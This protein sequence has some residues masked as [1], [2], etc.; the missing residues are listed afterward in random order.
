[1]R[2]F[3]YRYSVSMTTL[4]GYNTPCG[5]ATK[6]RIGHRIPKGLGGIPTNAKLARWVADYN[7]SLLPGG[8][9]SHIGPNGHCLVASI[10]DHQTDAVVATW[11]EL[12]G[13]RVGGGR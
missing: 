10:R 6:S 3:A 1:M 13:Q 11:T 8:V 5:W 7:A 4:V 9:N 2:D 12:L